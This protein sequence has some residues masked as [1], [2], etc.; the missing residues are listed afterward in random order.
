MSLVYLEIH[1]HSIFI[2]IFLFARLR[3][4]WRLPAVMSI[5]FYFQVCTMKSPLDWCINV[6]N[7][8]LLTLSQ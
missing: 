4:S 2:D 5:L 1:C 8:V 7:V 6:I 3:D